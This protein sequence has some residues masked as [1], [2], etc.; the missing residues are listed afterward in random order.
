MQRKVIAIDMDDTLAGFLEGLVEVVNR[1]E[2]EN[3]KVEDIKSWDMHKYFK[4]G[5]KIYNY[6]TYEL[7]RDLRVFDDAIEVVKSLQESYDVF[8]VSSA[9]S[10]PKSMLAKVE[11][12]EEW[13]PF[14]NKKNIVLCGDKSI[15]KADYMVDDGVHNLETFSGC[16]ILY[17]APHNQ[18]ENRFLR[19]YDWKDIERI[20]KTLGG[21]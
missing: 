14:I 19:A 16:S 12:L 9:T 11:W 4:C 7:F 13:F 8:I 6:L 2:G 17:D 21:M 1:L 10:T 15:I 5:H 3:V 18:N 20:F